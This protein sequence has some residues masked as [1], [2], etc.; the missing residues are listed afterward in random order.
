MVPLHSSLSES[1]T[2][3]LRL[4]C[5]G[6]ILAYCNLCLPGTSDLLTS[7][8]QASG[9]TD[10]RF[11]HVAQTGLELL[12]SGN[13]PALASQSAG[14][15]SVSQYAWPWK[16]ESHCSAKAG[17]QWYDLSSLQPPPPGLK[18][19]SCVSLPSV[20]H[21]TW[22]ALECFQKEFGMKDAV[23]SVLGTQCL[24]TQL[25]IPGIGSNLRLFKDGNKEGCDFEE[26]HV[27]ILKKVDIEEVLNVYN[28][29]LIVHSLTN[30]EI[31]KMVLNQGDFIY[32]DAEGLALSPRLECSGVILAHCNLHL[33][34][35][36]ETGFYHVG[37][38]GLK[39]LTSS[40]LP[41]S[42]SQST[43]ISGVS[44]CAQWIA[45]GLQEVQE[46]GTQGTGGWFSGP[47]LHVFSQ[48][49]GNTKRGNSTGIQHRVKQVVF[50][51]P[52]LECNSTFS[53]HRNLR[54]LGSSNSPA[55]ASQAAGITGMCHHIWLIFCI[56]SR[57]GVSSCWPG[58]SRSLDLVI[59][60]LRPPKSFL[61]LPR[62]KCN[63][64]I[65]AYCNLHLQGQVILLIPNSCDYRK[66]QIAEITGVYHHT[67]LIFV[68][69][70]EMGFY[71]VDQ[72]GLKLL[73]SGDPPTSTSQ[74]AR[75]TGMSHHARPT[76]RKTGSSENIRE[77]L[78]LPS[79]LQQN[80][81][82]FN[83]EF[84][85]SQM[86]RIPPHSWNCIRIGT[87]KRPSS[88]KCSCNK[89]PSQFQVK[90][91]PT[92]LAI[93]K[94]PCL[95]Q[96]GQG[97]VQCRNL[98]SPQPLPPGFKRFYCPSLPGSWD[99]RHEAPR[100]A[101][102]VSL[103][104]TEFLHVGQAGLNL[105]TAGDLSASAFQ[106]AGITGVSHQA[107]PV[108]SFFTSF[109]GACHHTPL[110]FIVLVE[111]RINH[112]GQA[113]LELLASG[114]PPTVVSQN[115]GITGVNH[116]PWPL[117][118]ILT[119]NSIHVAAKD[120][121]SFFILAEYVHI[122]HIFFI[123]SSMDEQL[124]WSAVAQSR[125]T[126]ALA[127]WAPVASPCVVQAGLKLLGSGDPTPLVSQS[128]G[129]TDV[130]HLE[131]EFHH[132][133]QAGLELLTSCDLPASSFQSSRITGVSHCARP[134]FHIIK[135]FKNLSSTIK[136]CENQA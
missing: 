110:S 32:G 83:F 29:T 108:I 1:L 107:W 47:T 60:P 91:H 93:K 125:L 119:S 87:L 15:T 33:P 71:H 65:L 123:K 127:S 113:G 57:D 112:V 54:L 131:R 116:R 56:F 59:H 118:K 40:D 104:E 133:G 41:A 6:A 31:A 106:S 30:S 20:S 2:L 9:T 117:P 27:N 64:V 86:K 11:Y 136:K 49:E 121:I 18:R 53:A 42:A 68:L 23:V 58:W 12:D 7:A 76:N 109:V 78:S 82:T 37:Q 4:E 85:I 69:L 25:C 96:T 17:V 72:A 79:T 66:N 130:S 8:F 55:S 100:P 36:R 111:M 22:P 50:L 102:F 39:L 35:S 52:R 88:F 26:F 46:D 62:L 97:W 21:H 13:L 94:L 48:T 43:G 61:L 129:I 10:M 28:E 98:G 134:D 77:R 135:Y 122:C 126:A 95:H 16:M 14:F 99:Y 45:R 63:G 132:V 120:M 70:V 80:F 75:V 115:A 103:V 81:V 19:S 38:A 89:G 67:Q 74:S 24:K 128:A 34:G 101:N 5:S 114:D 105:L 44:H 3:L 124:G 84:I 73:T 90:T 51:L 92:S